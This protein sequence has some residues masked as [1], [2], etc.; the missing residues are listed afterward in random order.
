VGRIHH[1]RLK[2]GILRFIHDLL[3]DVS[4]WTVT[5]KGIK[6]LMKLIKVNYK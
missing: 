5:V 4:N 2:A 3:K 6:K 1:T